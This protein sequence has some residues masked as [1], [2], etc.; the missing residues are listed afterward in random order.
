MPIGKFVIEYV[1]ARG[2]A[3][4]VVVYRVASRA[5]TPEVAEQVAQGT[6][7]SVGRMFPENPPDSFQILD[8]D[9]DVISQSWVSGFLKPFHV[10]STVLTKKGR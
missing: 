5:G 6:L 7:A 4:P 8:D 1:V 3:T 10:G 9:D 2:R